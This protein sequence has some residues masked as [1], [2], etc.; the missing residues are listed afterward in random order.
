[1]LAALARPRTHR[2][3]TVAGLS[4]DLRSGFLR[5]RRGAPRRSSS[6]GVSA[7]TDEPM[8]PSGTPGALVYVCVRVAVRVRVSVRLVPLSLSFSNVL[9]YLALGDL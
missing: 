4:I 2:C 3:A 1:M 8:A 9:Y 5:R 7:P 6:N